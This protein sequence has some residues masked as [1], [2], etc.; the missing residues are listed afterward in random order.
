M[1]SLR[2]LIN[3]DCTDA[4]TN[5]AYEEYLLRQS[6]YG[7]DCIFMLWRNSPSVIIGKNQNAY[8]EINRD[9]LDENGIKLVRRLTG[10]GA[11]F[12]DLGNVNFTFIGTDASGELDFS[13]YALPV[14]KAIASLGVEAELNGRNDICVSGK[15][16]SGTAQCIEKGRVLH[17]GTLL[18][19][20]DL[21]KLSGALK[22]NSDKLKDK[23]IRSVE[24]RVT[25]LRSVSGCEYAPLE[26][27]EYIAEHYARES[28]SDVI[29]EYVDP[30]K[31]DAVNALVKEKYSSFEWNYGTSPV[32]DYSLTK[33]FPYGTLELDLSCREGR[34]E[35][36]A[37]Y[38]DF[39][40]KNDAGAL[41]DK[42]VGVRLL[43]EDIREALEK[44]AVD[45]YIMGAG[46]EDILSLFEF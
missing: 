8:R 26:F 23:G 43:R 24:S 14:V 34:I 28:E 12:H 41:C 25:N 39:F 33:R 40:G 4:Y 3:R 30:S 42:L 37:L 18:Y 45:S 21:T 19:D 44:I 9:F 27:M 2:L 1:K 22:V 11:V 17:H 16:F 7:D 31:I 36:I 6:P 32:F 35:E 46:T 13:R 20:A 29:K 10:G 15:K 5:L 38:G